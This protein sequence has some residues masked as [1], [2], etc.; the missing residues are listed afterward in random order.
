M[1]SSLMNASFGLP[2]AMK[3]RA[4]V[5]LSALMFPFAERT[6]SRPPFRRLPRPL[7]RCVEP[8]QPL[9]SPRSRKGTRR[10]HSIS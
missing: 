1:R 7:H 5:S 6:L 4:Y 3:K 9:R 10:A 8:S 2:A